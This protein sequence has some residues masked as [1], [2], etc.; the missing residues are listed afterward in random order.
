MYDRFFRAVKQHQQPRSFIFLHHRAE[1]K[2][3][4]Y[5]AILI[6]GC[7]GFSLVVYSSSAL[8]VG[9]YHFILLGV[10]NACLSRSVA[11]IFSRGGVT[12]CQ[13]EV[14]HQ[15]FMSFLSPVVGCLLKTWL[16]KGVGSR[17]P[18]DPPGYAPVE[19]GE[20]STKITQQSQ[21]YLEVTISYL[22]I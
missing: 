22:Y 12:R 21:T 10:E 16:T 18:Q 20:H 2:R 17:A 3:Q 19:N 14:T 8:L 7:S 5:F 11:R 4:I 1:T 15:I 9:V 6:L 13:N